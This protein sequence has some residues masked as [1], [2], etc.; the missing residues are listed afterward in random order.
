MNL[1]RKLFHVDFI[2][3][4]S[5]FD[6]TRCNYM[7]TSK[8]A[9]VDRVRLWIPISVLSQLNKTIILFDFNSANFGNKIKDN[10]WITNEILYEIDTH[11]E[12]LKL[13]F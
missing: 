5:D 4:N 6:K 1:K 11:I 13:K 12:Y 3:A 8:E 9:I 2:A 10:F 7:K